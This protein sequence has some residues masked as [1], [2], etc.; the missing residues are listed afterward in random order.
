MEPA[1]KSFPLLFYLFLQSLTAFHGL[2]LYIIGWGLFKVVFHLKIFIYLLCVHVYV[3]L[4]HMWMC[5]CI[6][7]WRHV[8]DVLISS[9]CFWDRLSIWN[10]IL[11]APILSSAILLSLPCQNWYKSCKQTHVTFTGAHMLQLP[12]SCLFR[13]YLATELFL[14]LQIS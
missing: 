1:R 6:R 14:N 3:Q 13:Q 12:P 9:C 8:L 7:V 2:W 10:W 5:T 11:L 4:Y